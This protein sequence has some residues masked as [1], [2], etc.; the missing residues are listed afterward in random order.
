MSNVLSGLKTFGPGG[1]MSW[2]PLAMAAIEGD[3]EVGK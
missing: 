3:G 2:V 1:G